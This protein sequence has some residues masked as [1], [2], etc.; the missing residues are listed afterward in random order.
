MSGD[1]DHPRVEFQ[2]MSPTFAFSTSHFIENTML[3]SVIATSSGNR[4]CSRSNYY[5]FTNI[6]ENGIAT[7]IAIIPIATGH[8]F[9]VTSFKFLFQ[10]YT[11]SAPVLPHAQI[12]QMMVIGEF[13]SSF[14]P[15]IQRAPMAI[16]T[17]QHQR[18]EFQLS[19]IV[20]YSVNLV[21]SCH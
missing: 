20:L 2:S 9:L 1:L 11:R 19:S 17:A 6:L 10:V 16:A 12:F 8:K 18:R 14:G 4:V 5:N 13:P 21:T 3:F 15:E 7:I